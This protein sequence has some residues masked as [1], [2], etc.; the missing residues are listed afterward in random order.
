MG[1]AGPE[2]AAGGTLRIDVNPLLVAGG[3]GKLLN[4]RLADRQ[5]VG[6][7]EV[8]ADYS[9]HAVDIVKAQHAQACCELTDTTSPVI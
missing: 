3:I 4:A 5:P 6:V 9:Q 1:N 8:L 2:W 7:T